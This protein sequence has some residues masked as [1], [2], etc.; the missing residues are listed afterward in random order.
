MLLNAQP[1][2]RTLLALNIPNPPSVALIV[3]LIVAPVADSAPAGDT[4]N[5]PA[6]PAVIEPS[7][8]N[9]V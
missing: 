6:V 8:F 5:S 2:V 4:V 3:P 9:V 7:A 1:V